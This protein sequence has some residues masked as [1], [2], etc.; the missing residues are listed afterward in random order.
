MSHSTHTNESR[1]RHVTCINEWP[2]AELAWVMAHM[3]TSRGTHIN[4]SW[5]TY[6]K[7]MRKNHAHMNESWHTYEVVMARIRMSRVRH[8]SH[9]S[10]VTH[11]I[12]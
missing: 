11:I 12:V 9:V 3:S 2:L 8:V 4:E 10:H 1:I 7:V 6:E 5:H